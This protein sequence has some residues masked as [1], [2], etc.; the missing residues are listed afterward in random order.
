MLRQRRAGAL[1]GEHGAVGVLDQRVDHAGEA[2]AARGL[3]L[4][5][6][7][8]ALGFGLAGPADVQVNVTIDSGW[9]GPK[10]ASVTFFVVTR[11]RS[12]VQ[13]TTAGL[14]RAVNAQ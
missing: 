2:R 9:D 5:G 11:G 10:P 8:F 4:G 3:V 1:G 12:R 6:G 7:G 13:G 14:V